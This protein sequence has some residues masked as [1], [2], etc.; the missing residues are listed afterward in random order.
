M[1]VTHSSGPNTVVSFF[2]SGE[3]NRT[4]IEDSVIGDA[5]L[6]NDLIA[7]GLDPTTGTQEGTLSAVGFDFRH[8]KTDSLLNPRKGFQLAL[9]GEEAGILLPG[10]FNYY[11]LTV[12]GRHYQPVGDRLVVATHA[13]VGNIGPAGSGDVQVPFAKKYFLGG[14][15]TLRGWG[16]FEV[17]PLSS[18]GIPVGGNSFMVLST[19]ARA[20]V[21]GSFG[22]ALFLDAGNVWMTSGGFALNDLRYS[23]GPGVRY[24]TPVGPVRF[25][26]GYQLNPI[27]GLTKD[28]KLESSR[29]RFNFSIGEAF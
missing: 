19:E 21:K 4:S 23:V 25:D 17:S 18:S 2:V 22:A 10:T 28:G 7:L 14:A 11:A 6:V 27:P 16:R 26:V 9:H 5:S 20:D 15:T 8:A 24:R 12:D 1:A 29:W 3:R 13:Q